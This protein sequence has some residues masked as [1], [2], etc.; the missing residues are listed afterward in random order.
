M[1]K[2]ELKTR[3]ID[4]LKKLQP[5]LGKDYLYDRCVDNYVNAMVLETRRA[6]ALNLR[7]WHLKDNE[8]AFSAVRAKH[9]AGRTGVPQQYIYHLF[10][11]NPRTALLLESRKGFSKQG[12]SQLSTM[13]L[14]PIYE[15]LMIEEILNLK[16]EKN[17][18]LLDDIE[19]NY[20]HIIDVDTASLRSYLEKTR[21]TIAANNK[22]WRYNETL[23][24]NLAAAQ[25]LLTMVREADSSNPHSAYLR[26][27]YDTADTGRIYGQGYSLQ[28]MPKEVR[29]AALGFCHKYDFKACAFALMASLAHAIDPT[30]KISA[31]LDYIKNRASI[32]ERIA[33]QTGLGID[34]V[35]EIFTAMGFG[36]ELKNN[37]F[38]AIRHALDEAARKQHDKSVWV[39]KKVWDN[40][41]AG[42]YEQLIGDSTFMSIYDALQKINSTILK[43]FS[44]DNFVIGSATYSEI[45]PNAQKKKK[46]SNKRTNLQKLAWIYQALETLARQDFEALS[47]QKAL[48]TTHDCI[49]FKHKLS[50][51][52]IKDITWQLQQEYPYLRFEYEEIKPIATQEYYDSRY[53]EQHEDER[54][55]RELIQQQ[56]QLAKTYVSPNNWCM[57]TQKK[58]LTDDDYERQHRIDFL[59]DTSDASI[60]KYNALA[61]KCIDFNAECHYGY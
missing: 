27:R 14:N 11:K 28:R 55:H 30:L 51:E 35:K 21:Q 9:A 17:Q 23:L 37:P 53:A 57:K 5:Q 59:I 43:T 29:H 38:N 26:E 54:K 49:Y 16:V 46:K 31:V 58:E 41:G 1:M 15:D 47:G 12:V 48:L 40:L 34:L 45:D 13:R 52:D 39:E 4:E 44:D 60:E 42:A 10:Q 56:E 18:K 19:Q 33:K 32:R 36:A 22:G 6:L 20:T 24:R 7:G 8:F 25:Q 61:V 50:S 2:N 3:L